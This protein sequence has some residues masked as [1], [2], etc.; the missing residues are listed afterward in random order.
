LE[1]IISYVKIKEVINQELISRIFI[2]SA[3]L[4][5]YKDLRLLQKSSLFEISEGESI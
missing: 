5:K 1:E 2:S 4:K 3:K